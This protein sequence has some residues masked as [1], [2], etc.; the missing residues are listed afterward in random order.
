[1]ENEYIKV[2]DTV[3]YKNNWNDIIK[4]A[5][6]TGITLTRDI[7]G[8]FGRQVKKVNVSRIEYSLITLDDGHWCYGSLLIL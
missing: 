1:M 8:K 5:K 3:K 7:N 2:G 6:V 4:S